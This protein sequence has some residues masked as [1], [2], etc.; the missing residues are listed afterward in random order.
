[1]KQV[2]SVFFFLGLMLSAKAQ[3]AFA[4]NSAITI[5]ILQGGG[6]L[7]GADFE[8]K[9]LKRFGFQVG[10]GIFSYGAAINFHFKED[11]RS[12][13]LSF[14][15]WHQGF[16]NTFSENLL[17]PTFVYRANK[18]FT[19]QLGIGKMLNYGPAMVT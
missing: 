14:T 4:E 3:G 9:P 19:A 11:I 5:G 15:Y 13:F 10:A 7:V 6:G 2:L 17:G 12:S 1:M 18:I 16:G 8:L